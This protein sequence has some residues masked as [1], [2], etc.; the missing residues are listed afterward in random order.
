[1]RAPDNHN[2]LGVVQI[3]KNYF[4]HTVKLPGADNDAAESLTVGGRLGAKELEVA[5]RGAWASIA[6]AAF[7]IPSCVILLIG[8][9]FR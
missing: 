6:I 2:T 4:A 9:L 7:V 3:K 5:G 1:M 8:L